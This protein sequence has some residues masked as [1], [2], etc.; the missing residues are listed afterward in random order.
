MAADSV[1]SAVLRL[2][3]KHEDL[4]VYAIYGQHDI[5]GH[6][7]TTFMNSPLRVLES[8]GYV[9]VLDKTKAILGHNTQVYGASFGQDVPVPSSVIKDDINILVIHE[10]IGN[11]PLWPGQELQNPRMFL[12]THPYYNLVL[13]GDYHYAF[14]DRMKDQL[15]LNPG[16]L[17][18]KNLT[19]I[20]LGHEPSVSI[21]DIETLEF[22]TLKLDVEPAE[23]I[24][25]MTRRESR[26]SEALN[27]FAENLKESRK[28]NKRVSWKKILCDVIADKKVSGGAQDCIDNSMDE[29]SGRN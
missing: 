28:G 14:T 6:S 1:K 4:P 16:A 13:C 5:S 20:E 7:A 25:D 11:R 23:K 21:V 2:L 19:D 27:K 22:E 29:I 8:S 17:M 10:M 12:R 3:R 24:F 9:C 18:R 26:D 15:I